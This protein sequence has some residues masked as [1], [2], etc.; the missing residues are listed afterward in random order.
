MKRFCLNYFF[1]SWKQTP[2]S[3]IEAVRKTLRSMKQGRDPDSVASKSEQQLINKIKKFD[4]SFHQLTTQMLYNLRFFKDF[5]GS[6][7][8]FHTNTSLYFIF[9][10]VALISHIL[11]VMTFQVLFII[12]CL[13]ID[14]YC[15]LLSIL[16]NFF[17]INVAIVGILVSIRS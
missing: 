3:L 11:N 13:S 5:L 7:S 15:Y 12:Y 4:V 17:S 1:S 6:F 2:A 14:I 8:Y 16:L 10:L 9:Q